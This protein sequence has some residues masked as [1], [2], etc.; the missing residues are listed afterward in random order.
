M[1]ENFDASEH[2]LQSLHCETINGYIYVC[3]ADEAPDFKDFC[4]VMGRFTVPHNLDSCKV[5][6]ESNLIEKGNWKLVF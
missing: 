5:A 6:F 1:G 4:D 3:V 2:G